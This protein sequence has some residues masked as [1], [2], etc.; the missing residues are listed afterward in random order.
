MTAVGLPILTQA[1]V[2]VS[3]LPGKWANKR[4]PVLDAAQKTGLD[5]LNLGEVKGLC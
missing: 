3:T 2:T 5:G 4:R 1:K